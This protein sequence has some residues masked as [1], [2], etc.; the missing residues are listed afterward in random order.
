VISSSFTSR[1][2][3][4]LAWFL[5]LG[6]IGFAAGF[7]G[8]IAFNPEANQGPLVGILIS[9][10]GGA[11]LGVF[12]VAA[13]RVL[14]VRP[15]WQ[16]QMLGA[17]G[18]ILGVVTLGYCLPGP[19]FRG[20]VVDSR[21]LGCKPTAKA[22]DD[23]IAY[24]EKRVAE[25]TWAPPRPAWQDDVRRRL[26][27]DQAVVLDVTVVRRMG[28]YESRKPWSKGSLSAQGWRSVN[29]QKSYYA[30]YAGGSC[31]DYPI[32]TQSVHFV[33]YEGAT[34][35]SAAD[36]PPREL[37]TFLDLQSVEKVPAEYLI[38]SGN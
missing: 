7:F 15:Q 30:Q 6:G 35:G 36:W 4:V 21:I 25:V 3:S 5:I 19:A 10:P 37:P 31:A 32:G 12:L 23:A 11:F 29:E 13:C 18:A 34:A 17:F 27:Q 26:A 28:I 16:W 2:P 22:T 14:G 33:P 20:Y 38:F 1:A 8:P 9:G 24:W